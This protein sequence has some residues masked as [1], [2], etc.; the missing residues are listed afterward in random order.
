[1]RH[2]DISTFVYLCLDDPHFVFTSVSPRQVDSHLVFTSVSPRQVDSPQQKAATSVLQ[3]PA[4][5]SDEG[6][7]FPPAKAQELGKEL[8]Q[9][10]IHRK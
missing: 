2:V 1:M 7:G 10:I 5:P 4:P 8:R 3:R 9:S 6:L